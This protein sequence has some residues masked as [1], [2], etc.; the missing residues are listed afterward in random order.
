MW[1]LKL[2]WEVALVYFYAYQTLMMTLPLFDFDSRV[3]SINFKKLTIVVPTD[4]NEHISIPI[5]P[6]KVLHL[7]F[8]SGFWIKNLNN[9]K[10]S[11]QSFRPAF[12]KSITISW[13]GRRQHLYFFTIRI[14]L[15][16]I[17]AY[18]LEYKYLPHIHNLEKK[19]LMTKLAEKSAYE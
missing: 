15:C 19:I 3:I 7:L 6:P 14:E 11:V 12:L 17:A 4:V 16:Y 18:I 2:D 10:C 9:Q 8:H 1:N 5:I 13:S